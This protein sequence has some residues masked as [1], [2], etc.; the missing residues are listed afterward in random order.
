MQR[1][2][3]LNLDVIHP[4]FKDVAFAP[5]VQDF[6]KRIK[7]YRPKEGLFEYRNA[8]GEMRIDPN[9]LK[10][11]SPA[12]KIKISKDKEKLI[13][14]LTE[15]A[16]KRDDE[17]FNNDESELVKEEQFKKIKEDD[18]IKSKSSSSTLLHKRFII[19]LFIAY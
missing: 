10:F 16:N 5:D 8:R 3:I 11:I 15:E 4:M 14:T 9:A 18:I 7:E 17:E 12:K 6:Y 1:L 13:K 19:Y 2:K